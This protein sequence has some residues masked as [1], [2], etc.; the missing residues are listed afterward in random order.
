MMFRAH[1]QTFLTRVSDIFRYPPFKINT[2]YYRFFKKCGFLMNQRWWPPLST[3]NRSIRTWIFIYSSLL[4][5]KP[6][7]FL[8]ICL[9]ASFD[10]SL[11]SPS[12]SG[13]ALDGLLVRCMVIPTVYICDHERSWYI[14]KGDQ[15]RRYHVFSLWAKLASRQID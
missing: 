2:F 5:R 3:R 13:T 11:V 6:E 15:S 9:D 7:G 14:V 4:R 10:Q 12:K 1:K 8:W